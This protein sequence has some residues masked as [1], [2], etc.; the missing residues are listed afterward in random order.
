MKL[1]GNARIFASRAPVPLPSASSLCPRTRTCAGAQLLPSTLA[2]SQA[3]SSVQG[4]FVLTF[5]FFV[6]LLGV[7]LLIFWGKKPYH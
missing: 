4:W 7:G 1:S 5:C 6:R 3:V 2:I